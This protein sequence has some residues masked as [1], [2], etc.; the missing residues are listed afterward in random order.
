MPLIKKI[1]NQSMAIALIALGAIALSGCNSNRPVTQQ[2]LLQTAEVLFAIETGEA[3][4]THFAEQTQVAG[5]TANAPTYTSTFTPTFTL[6]PTN[7]ETSAPTFTLTP[8]ITLTPTKFAGCYL[9]VDPDCLGDSSCSQ[10]A[11]RNLSNSPHTVLLAS[12]STGNS[13]K[14]TVPAKQEC[15]VYMHQGA[16]DITFYTC[17]G[18]PGNSYRTSSGIT[19]I[20]RFNNDC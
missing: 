18:Q 6:T 13:L 12:V 20:T 14:F 17:L 16:V 7:T 4:P 5:L 11:F 10:W 3:A 2:E 1:M 8:T 19:K 9:Y 15:F